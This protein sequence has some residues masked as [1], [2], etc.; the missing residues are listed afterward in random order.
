MGMGQGWLFLS[1]VAMGACIGIFYDVFRIFRKVTSHAGWAVQVEDFLFWVCA[2][3]GMFYFMLH[4]S[5]GDIRLVYIL[6]AGCGVTLYFATASPFIR[7]FSVVII[8][9]MQRVVA[10]AVGV[11]LLP[12]RLLFRILAPVIKIFAK[13]FAKRRRNLRN[14]AKYGKIKK[15]LRNWFIMRR[16]V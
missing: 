2:T 14:S 7:K 5:F 12:L 3:V 1:T 6:G 4:N 16:K 9:F 13:F 15:T 11:L 8:R 10:G